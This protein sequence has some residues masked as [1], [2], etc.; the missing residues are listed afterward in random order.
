MKLIYILLATYNGEKYLRDQ[1]DSLL[2]Q[3]YQNWV[4]WIHDDN[5]NDNTV[6]IIREYER[7]YPSKIEFLDDDISTGGA[8]ENFS[9]LIQK[10]DNNFDYV[11]FCDQDDIWLDDKIKKTLLKME[12]VD[13]N[14]QKSPIVIF[15]DL[16]VVDQNLKILAESMWKYQKVKPIFSQDIYRLATCN[17]ITGCTMML[18]KLAIREYNFSKNALMH[19]WSI[20]L[21]VLKIGGKIAYVNEGLILYRQHSFNVCGA[22]NITLISYLNHIRQFNN[23]LE[24][25]LSNY[26][27]LKELQIFTNIFSFI[28]SKIKTIYFRFIKK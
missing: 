27:M 19:D 10:I 20:A 13:R 22:K 21:Q 4:L 9:Y 5:S 16:I 11:M 2:K 28:F 15:T 8:K 7:K 17:V 25:N 3:T 1:L 26:N 6:N 24:A 12:E 18:N 23:S 14:F